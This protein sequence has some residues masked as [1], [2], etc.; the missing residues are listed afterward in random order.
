MNVIVNVISWLG[1]IAVVLA[2]GLVSRKK[3]DGGSRGYQ[4]LNLLGS[5]FLMVNT[6]YLA[7]YPS[8]AINIVWASIALASIVRPARKSPFEDR[9]QAEATRISVD[10]R[11]V[12]ALSS[13]A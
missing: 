2:Y 12:P 7:A 6:I 9:V 11:E 5:A 10:V 3:L 1:S 4:A 13:L 8:A